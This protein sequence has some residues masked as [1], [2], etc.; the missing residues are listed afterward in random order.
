MK[1]AYI[2]TREHG[3]SDV[4]LSQVA[5]QLAERG[6]HLAGVVQTNSDRPDCHHCDMDVAVLPDGPTI[7]ISQSLG[8]EAKGCKLDPSSL[9][10]AVVEVQARL[11]EKTDLL[12]LNKF[13]KHEADGR[14]FRDLIAEALSADIPV[15]TAVNHL[16]EDAFLEFTAGLATKLPPDVD[17]LSAWASAV[18]VSHETAA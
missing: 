15:L 10:A 17:A 14:G 16:N 12:V 5:A 4:L 13:G 3:K 6:L 11:G 18:S 9:E 1:I 2:T 7:R 8:R